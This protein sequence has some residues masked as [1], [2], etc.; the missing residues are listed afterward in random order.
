MLLN[1]LKIAF[2]HLLK[3]RFF[4]ILNI[5]GLALGMSCTLLIWLWVKDEMSHDRFLPGLEEIYAV[6]INHVDS[7]RTETST[8]T[9]GPLAD[10]LKKDVPEIAYVAKVQYPQEI[11]IRANGKTTK[12]S[13]FFATAD[14]FRVF[15]Y[16]SAYGNP[17]A[18]LT[19]VDK[20]VLSR[21]TAEKFFGTADV[22][23]QQLQFNND[24]YYTVGAVVENP[25]ANGTLR[26]DWMINYD[27]QEAD[28]KKKWGN[29]F[30]TTYVRLAPRAGQAKAEANM[31]GIYARYTDWEQAKNIRPVLQPMRDVHLYSEYENGRA[32]GGRIEYVRIFAVVALFILLIACVNFMNLATARSATRAKEVGVRKVVGAFR[33]SLVGQFL[34]E[35]LLTSLMAVVGALLLTGLVLPVFNAVFD[36]QI[37]L[38]LSEPVLWQSIAVLVAVTG[39]VSGSYPALFLSSLQ[40]IRV[41]KG[42]LR[43]G[44]GASQFRRVLVVFQFALSS[45]LIIGMLVVARQMHY[46]Q[47]KNLGLDRE[48]ILYV[49]IEGEL[50]EPK[51]METFRQELLRQPSVAAATVT[52]SLPQNIQSSSGDLNWPGRDPKKD[53]N[54]SAMAIG[55][56]FVKTMGITLVDGRDFSKDR[57]TDSTAYLINESAARLMGMQD[58]VGREVSFWRGKGPIVGVMKDFHLQSLHQ[59]ITPLV[60]CLLPENVSYLLVRTQAGQTPQALADLEQLVKRFNPNYPFA[61]HFADEEYDR[62]YRSE[63]QVSLLINY[64]GVLAIVISCLGLFGLAAF[65][66]QQRTK[67][68]GIRKVLGASVIS[69]VSMLSKDFLKLVL[70]ALVLAVPVAGW[71]LGKWLGSFTYNAGLAWWIY[72]VA[73]LLAVGIALLTIGFQ[74]A[75][76]ALTNP[77][78]SL[79]SE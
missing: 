24:K 67:E 72:A 5:A 75:K 9:N 16:A 13:G 29:T 70:S 61:Y 1:H 31:R 47:T 74:S 30:C 34:T 33:S 50:E 14:F 19:D 45:F 68:I 58:P 60:L 62:M 20:I 11:L 73:G 76:A 39:L 52:M 21:R 7:A 3:H 53:N 65:T 4:S 48:N 27:V 28:W 41:L 37:V 25:P 2:R 59:P 56:D 44:A 51:R 35:S 17:A 42:T 6:R 71:A 54:V 18:A 55:Y 36:K 64:F 12:E 23:G 57:A 78:K 40:P 32:T 69:L 46:I 63:Q 10:V 43:F 22:L 66:A 79:R 8:H 49:H 26:F 15:P 38:D 77:V